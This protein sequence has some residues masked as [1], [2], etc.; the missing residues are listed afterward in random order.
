MSDRR[1]ILLALACVM[2]STRL[3]AAGAMDQRLSTKKPAILMMGAD[4]H[5]AALM[6]DVLEEREVVH[7]VV[8]RWVPPAEYHKYGMVAIAG[9]LPEAE[10]SPS[11]YEKDDLRHV[12]EFLR[13]GGALL[14][15]RAGLGVFSSEAGTKYFDKLI[16]R[17]Y[18]PK[19]LGGNPTLIRLPEHP[20]VRHLKPKEE[21][22]PR[23]LTNTLDVAEEDDLDAELGIDEEDKDAEDDA[24]AGEFLA[25]GMKPQR[26]DVYL[27]HPWLARTRFYWL[28]PTKGECV[29]GAPV[30]HTALYRRT[31]GK[32]Q[33]IYVGWNF[34]AKSEAQERA[35]HHEILHNIVAQIP[36]YS[37][38][39]YLADRTVVVGK[40]PF[41]WHRDWGLTREQP[42]P[43]G[44]YAERGMTADAGPA[45]PHEKATRIRLDAGIDEYESSFL[46][47]SNFV[48]P[49]KLLLQLGELKSDAGTA[50]PPECVR[51]RVQRPF[52][53]QSLARALFGTGYRRGYGP[54]E[55]REEAAALAHH[56]LS[57]SEAALGEQVWLFGLDQVG[58]RRGKDWLV[59]ADRADHIPV[60]LTFEP[61]PDVQPGLYRG[62]LVIRA[63][64]ESVA[65]LPVELKLW[66]VR[67]PPPGILPL[68]VLAGSAISGVPGSGIGQGV[69]RYERDERRWLMHMRCLA[70]HNCD[71]AWLGHEVIDRA[72]IVG[73]SRSLLQALAEEPSRCQQDELPRLDFSALDQFLEPMVGRGIRTVVTGDVT[74]PLR[75]AIL[76]AVAEATGRS[77]AAIAA[78]HCRR[79]EK[80]FLESWMGYLGRHGVRAHL[81]RLVDEIDEV[82]EPGRIVYER[83]ATRFLSAGLKPGSTFGHYTGA[84]P[85]R[86][87]QLMPATRFWSIAC[88]TASSFR[89]ATRDFDML[90]PQQDEI[91]PHLKTRSAILAED[92]YHH[93]WATLHPLAAYRGP[94]GLH[95]YPDQATDVSA[96]CVEM[97]GR[98][99]VSTTLEALRDS[100]DS[101]RYYRQLVREV[102]PRLPQEP[103]AQLR[104]ELDKIVGSQGTAILKVRQTT[105]A[106][107][108]YPNTGYTWQAFA[109][110]SV[111]A[112]LA[113][114]KRAHAALLSLSERYAPG[115]Q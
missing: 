80:W 34:F 13:N 12:D 100:I 3:C 114:F 65:E 75:Q 81:V 19:E 67:R 33:L 22:Q 27:Q 104:T 64:G 62:M 85:A 54:V 86:I 8:T 36:L 105:I 76:A 49:R 53:I 108:A 45:G 61:R 102:L 41:V 106:G 59:P 28:L 79:L 20:F 52:T 91:W 72:R 77:D 47:V 73:T 111:D 6:A 56:L 98:L 14:L 21:E 84:V 96:L 48:K 37:L 25:E 71:T 23:E 113:D 115:K 107:G 26:V 2:T 35:D 15:F 1:P 78:P 5:D 18:R 82:G 83:Q 4:G 99:V 87:T 24:E 16:G 63:D 38:T 93:A 101:L 92:A 31:L 58:E 110:P 88:R 94:V 55:S 97:S 40:D 39:D 68:G 10:I 57:R 60:W 69:S 11:C 103:A 30:G 50:L 74:G 44:W 42:D 43:R 46:F 109:A 51:I 89:A 70:E 66:P 7:Y 32:G 17:D 9:S 90:R 95:V 112:G 29:I